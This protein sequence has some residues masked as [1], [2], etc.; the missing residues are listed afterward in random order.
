MSV[1]RSFLY[2]VVII[3][4]LACGIGYAWWYA[5]SHDDGVLF[6]D[7]ALSAPPVET[8]SYYQEA[9]DAYQS[10][11]FMEAIELLESHLAA[12][13]DHVDA[14]F[15]M[16]LCCLE[17]GD[18]LRAIELMDEVRINDPGY[19]LDATWYRGLACLKTDQ[20]EQARRMMDELS[21]CED[22]FYRAKAQI[23]LDRFL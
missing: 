4:I 17:T 1:S 13:P 14:T 8:S 9:V 15:L 10:G 7:K 22:S 2:P 16:G 21:S 5:Q 11:A 20:T 19:Y 12:H 6:S 18:E 3:L 23:I